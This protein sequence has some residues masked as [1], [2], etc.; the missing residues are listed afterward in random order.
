MLGQFAAA[1]VVSHCG[2]SRVRRDSVAMRQRHEKCGAT[3]A[4]WT[5]S[6]IL[7]TRVMQRARL[8]R[9]TTRPPTEH[10]TTSNPSVVAIVVLQVAGFLSC[11]SS[12]SC[13]CPASCS[14]LVQSRT[15][16]A[17]SK[18]CSHVGLP[19]QDVPQ[20][21]RKSV[22]PSEP[23]FVLH[24]NVM[25]SKIVRLLPTVCACNCPVQAC[26][27][28][29]ALVVQYFVFTG[30]SEVTRRIACLHHATERARRA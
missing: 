14:C 1:L 27:A 7:F 6:G 28:V 22:V 3:V 19:K 24:A 29:Y 18:T 25:L 9:R 8:G 21:G 11:S 5:E 30:Q 13:S 23:S 4:D 16:G 20:V 17:V 2:L 15:G 26:V 12:S 10:F